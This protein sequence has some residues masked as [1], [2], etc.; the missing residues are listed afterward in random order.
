MT[1]QFRLSIHLPDIDTAGAAD[2]ARSSFEH[3]SD[4][5]RDAADGIDLER[6]LEEAGDRVK[7]AIQSSAIKAAIARLERELPDTDH[8]RYDRAYRR[9]R[10]QG[11]SIWLA[12]GIAVGVSA[13]IGAALLLEPKGG[14]ARRE[15]LKAR[16]RGLA[17]Q[18]TGKVRQV[19]EQ[20]RREADD[21][22]AAATVAV[23]TPAITPPAPELPAMDAATV[24]VAPA[25]TPA[26]SPP[27]DPS[28]SGESA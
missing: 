3:L 13:G 15:A 26:V 9:G 1:D 23:S 4:L 17:G 28:L 20:R 11:R 12:V 25:D 2:A 27:G 21:A 10:T 8:G 18:S 24:D 6:H 19:V 7:K 14:K 22:R 5:A 16:A